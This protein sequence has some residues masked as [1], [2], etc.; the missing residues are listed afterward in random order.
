MEVASCPFLFTLTHRIIYGQKSYHPP[1]GYSGYEYELSNHLNT[2]YIS[3][4]PVRVLRTGAFCVFQ[5]FFEKLFYSVWQI[6]GASVEGSRKGINN[7]PPGRKGVRTWITLI[8][9]N[10]RQDV[11]LMRTANARYATN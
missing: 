8:G 4:A 7:P 11:S 3:F 5:N 6:C 10:G 1:S 9:W 2:A